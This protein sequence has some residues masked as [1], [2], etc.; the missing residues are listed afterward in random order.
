ML[1]AI[2]TISPDITI[3]FDKNTVTYPK[4][5]IWNKTFPIKSSPLTISVSLALLLSP[6]VINP[7][8]FFS[9]TLWVTT[10]PS[11]LNVIISPTLTSSASILL[12]IAKSPVLI[13]G[14]IL[15]LN[16]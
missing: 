10:F 11:Y 5:G 9:T 3:G 14:Y 15:P 13:S 6:F 2:R 1:I 12:T 8:S 7:S 16:I 4:K